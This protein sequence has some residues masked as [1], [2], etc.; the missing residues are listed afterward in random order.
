MKKLFIIILLLVLVGCDQSAQ[1]EDNTTIQ[2]T[3][4]A[5]TTLITEDSNIY[6][7]I[8]SYNSNGLIEISPVAGATGYTVFVSDNTGIDQEL[9][10]PDQQFNLSA[11]TLI[12]DTSVLQ[13]NHLYS[14]YAESVHDSNHSTYVSNTINLDLFLDLGEIEYSYNIN[15]IDRLYLF[16]QEISDIY[17]LFAYG[18]KLSV[19]DYELVDGKLFI[20]HDFLNNNY[21][22]NLGFYTTVYTENG[23][24]SVTINFQDSLTPAILS[25]NE[26]VFEGED[27]EFVFDYAG[28]QMEDV[29]GSLISSSDFTLVDNILTIEADFIEAL[30]SAQPQRNTVILGYQLRNETDIVIGYLFIQRPVAD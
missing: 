29:N 20:N 3:T 11:D 19:S 14:I 23:K 2:T 5:E 25:A 30:F 18:H 8:I 12:F 26:V 27:L 28:G 15:N 10:L 4:Q 22:L 24:Y 16:E 17:Y 7:L 9:L 6:A 21:L 1:T 13:E